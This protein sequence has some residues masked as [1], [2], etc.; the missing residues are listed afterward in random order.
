MTYKYEYP[1][2]MITVDILLFRYSKSDLEI[3]L[4]QRKQPPFKNQ[5][6][7][8][9]GYA[10]IE[11][12]LLDAAVRELMEETGV[13]ADYLFPLHYA[14]DP[15]RDPRGRTISFI[16]GGIVPPP[17]PEIRGGNDASRAAWHSLMNLPKL[18]FDHNDIVRR[19]GKLAGNR[20]N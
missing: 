6:A 15:R 18:A 3:L 8:P 12:R 9:G 11:E 7:F 10:K 13:Q 17:F 16:F 4:I 1:R 2:P 14:D 19:S 20:K 5:W